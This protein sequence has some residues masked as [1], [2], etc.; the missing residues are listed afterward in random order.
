MNFRVVESFR[1]F[2]GF[3]V[4]K[5]VTG[6]KLVLLIPRSGEIRRKSAHLNIMHYNTGNNVT[7]LL[8]NLMQL[9][10]ECN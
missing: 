2:S 8:E 6:P 3:F 4:I 1:R 7:F 10:A 5:V 9:R